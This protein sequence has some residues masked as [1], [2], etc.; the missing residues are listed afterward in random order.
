MVIHDVNEWM[1]KKTSNEQRATSMDEWINP[2]K[3]KKTKVSI[4]NEQMG[5]EET[6]REVRPSIGSLNL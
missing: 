4:A 1:T 5:H 2:W 3:T 6:Y